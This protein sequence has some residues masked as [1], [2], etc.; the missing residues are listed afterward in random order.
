MR[1]SKPS[2]TCQ[3]AGIPRNSGPAALASLD[4]SFGAYRARIAVAQVL[5]EGPRWQMVPAY[6]L[7]GLFFVIWLRR[8]VTPAGKTLDTDGPTGLPSAWPSGWA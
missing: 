5:M 6:A 1:P 3:S 7:A 4:A 8:H 2:V